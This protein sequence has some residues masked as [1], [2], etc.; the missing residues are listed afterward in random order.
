MAYTDDPAR[1]KRARS[2]VANAVRGRDKAAE[3][4]ARRE[5]AL[6]I[7]QREIDNALEV[8]TLPE[9]VDAILTERSVL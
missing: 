3:T 6:G 9:L 8:W 5:M 2:R 4:E 1:V 7:V